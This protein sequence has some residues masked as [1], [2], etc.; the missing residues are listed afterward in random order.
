MGKD[1]GAQAFLATLDS[2]RHVGDIIDAVSYYEM[3]QDE[4]RRKGLDLTVQMWLLKLMVGS[5][6]SSY[7]QQDEAHGGQAH[8][9]AYGA[10]PQSKGKPSLFGKGFKKMFS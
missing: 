6:V 5:V 10:A 3:E 1:S 4:F 7:D 9:N 2:D 8:G